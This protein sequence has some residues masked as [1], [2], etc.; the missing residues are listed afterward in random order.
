MNIPQD[1][2]VDVGLTVAGYVAS[3]LIAIVFY[4]MITR[5]SRTQ[6]SNTRTI[7]NEPSLDAAR[8]AAVSPDSFQFVRFDEVR[9]HAGTT[10]R[11]PDSRADQRR[12]LAETIATARRML[13]S[14][15]PAEQI[16]RVLP[17]SDAEL[18]LLQYEFNR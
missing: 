14:G 18:A 3:G 2:L 10:A 17:V 12:N 4:S 16:K 7:V 8:S 15:T 1:V 11:R 9:S 6:T 13:Q 5:R